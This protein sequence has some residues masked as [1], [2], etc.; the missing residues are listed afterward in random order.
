MAKEEKSM[1]EYT[2]EENRLMFLL[3]E[4]AENDC[5]LKP[6]FVLCFANSRALKDLVKRKLSV[7]RRKIYKV[8][9]KVCMD[10]SLMFDVV[11]HLFVML[12]F[13]WSLSSSSSSLS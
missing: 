10:V 1:P 8:G 13:I 7:V 2:A 5:K 3:M 6:F 9:V 4:N 12:L 11:L